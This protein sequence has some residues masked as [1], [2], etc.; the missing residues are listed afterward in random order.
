VWDYNL[1]YFVVNN[2]QTN[3]V[4]LEALDLL[5]RLMD[6][7][8]ATIHEMFVS[9]FIIVDFLKQTL[10]DRL[11][12]GKAYRVLE[13][14]VYNFRPSLF[15]LLLSKLDFFTHA[16][17]QL[18]DGTHQAKSNMMRLLYAIVILKAELNQW[19]A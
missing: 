10:N 6:V 5:D 14:M 9:N 17:Q 13:N 4:K 7:Y 18:I 19:E 12:Q 16:G 8:Q 11:T 15:W 2:F 3:E 1:L